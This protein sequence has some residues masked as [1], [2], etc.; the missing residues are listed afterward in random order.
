M[1]IPQKGK[2]YVVRVDNMLIKEPVK[3]SNQEMYNH[4]KHEEEGDK[5]KKD[6]KE[7]KKLKKEGRVSTLAPY[8]YS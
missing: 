6:K 4:L 3:E 5:K 1:S 8:M 7:V 2:A